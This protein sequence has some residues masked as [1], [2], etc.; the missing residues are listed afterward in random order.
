MKKPARPRVKEPDP[1]VTVYI[2]C[3]NYGKYLVDAIESVLK[4]TID[5]WELLIID[6][7]STD[8]TGEVIELYKNHPR[9]RVFKTRGI[10][11]PGGANLA[12]KEARG[13]YL[14]RLDADDVF[15]ENILLVLGNYLDRHPDVVLV[16][17]DYFLIDQKGKIFAQERRE[18]I[19][20]ANHMLDLPAHGACTMIRKKTLAGLGGYREDLGVQDGYDIWSRIIREYKCANVNIPLFYYRR[21]GEN[22][23]ENISRILEARRIIKKDAV[24]K[25]LK[26]HRP[27]IGVIPCRRNYDAYPDMW[28]QEAVGGETLLD[29]S[30][31]KCVESDILDYIVVVSDNP[32]VQSVMSRHKDN[33][34]RYVERSSYNTINSVPIAHSLEPIVKKFDK[35]CAGV[36]VLAFLQAPFA[37]RE[38][39]EEAVYTL[40]VNQADC[41]FAVTEV[42][43]QLYHKVSHGLVPIHSGGKLSSDF[44][45][46]YS[47]CKVSLAT[48]NSNLKTGSLMGARFVHYVIPKDEAFFIQTKQDMEV[49]RILM[50]NDENRSLHLSAH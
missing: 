5:D 14:V 26:L 25:E 46:I 3:H 8:N 24:I 44:D 37:S 10:G 38:T 41:S 7:N 4:Q 33:R 31:K 48:R 19:Y 20:Q 35:K 40:L 15:D 6:D 13:R 27:I 23:T 50:M 1:R 34:V 2:C 11:L 21:H 47:D 12:L 28:K 30:I 17:P 42:T 45:A 32:D 29:L 16:Y 36:S 9:I 39:L 49:L 43:Q 22:S 18:K